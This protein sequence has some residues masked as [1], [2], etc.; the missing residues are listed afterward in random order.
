M[1]LIDSIMVGRLGATPLA[2]SAFANGVINIFFIFGLG[3]ANAMGPL[4]SKL[5]GENRENECGSMLLQG[6]YIYVGIGVVLT[7]TISLLSFFL[8]WFKQPEDVTAEALDF[9][10]ICGLS[11]IPAL[12]FHCYKQF[13]E[14]YGK[15]TKPMMMLMAAL[16]LNVFLNWLLIYGNWGF[17]KLGL[18]GSGISTFTARVFLM[19]F[20]MR[21]VHSSSR[22][23]QAMQSFKRSL[24]SL[25]LTKKIFAISVPSGIQVLCEVSVFMAAGIMAGWLGT[26][27]LAA[28]QVAL[29]IASMTFMF[30][31]GTSLGGAL[32][33]SLA[34]GRRDYM[35]VRQAG[36]AAFLMVSVGM[37]LLAIL[38]YFFRGD[39]P[40]IFINDG[41]VQ[42]L[43]AKLLVIAA[44]FQLFDGIQAVGVGVQRGLHDVRV[45][46]LITILAYGI[47]CLPLA[48]LLGFY[49]D[50]GV[51]GIWT[52][53]LIGLAV[54]AILLILRFEFKT[55]SLIRQ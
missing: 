27:T 26:R 36:H 50:Y 22:Y 34:L 28:H 41:E 37:L 24:L 21:E 18:F 25:E 53:L 19:V 45:P 32:R 49:F 11:I 3:A 5:H 10:R 35:G 16:G 29:S 43:S 14:A 55:R 44:I 51:Q 23:R 13:I 54:A 15:T 47:V 42:G 46:T 52:G 20:A 12:I 7:A 31:L 4:L 9:Y 39:L 6:L 1:G 33:V 2:A 38:V 17:P 40:K 48:Y 8:H 30:A